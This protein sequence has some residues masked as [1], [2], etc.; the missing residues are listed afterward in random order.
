MVEEEPNNSP[1][2]YVS[3]DGT[4]AYKSLTVHFTGSGTD[5][6]GSITSYHWDFGDGST[7]D[8]QNPTHTFHHDGEDYRCSYSIKLTVTDDKGAEDTDYEYITLTG[9]KMTVTDSYYSYYSD[10]QWYE[11]EVET[12]FDV[13]TQGCYELE[14]TKIGETYQTCSYYEPKPDEILAGNSA[15]WRVVFQDVGKLSGWKLIWKR[16]FGDI[17]ANV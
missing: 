3:A 16:S 6:D 17:E 13:D 12:C 15:S 4:E 5:I 7:S 1:N 10:V 14:T 2:A 9:L 11:I 8:E